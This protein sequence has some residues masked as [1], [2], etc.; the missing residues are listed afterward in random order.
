MV[1]IM[2]MLEANPSFVCISLNTKNT[3]NEMKWSGILETLWRDP[4][5]R[6]LWYY[7]WRVKVQS[8]YVGLGGGPAMTSIPFL[9]EEGEYMA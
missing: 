2:Y 9:Y 3:F 7:F 5:L 6:E 1:N 4:Y 8:S